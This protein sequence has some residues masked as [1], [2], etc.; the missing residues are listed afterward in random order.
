MSSSFKV[1]CNY[2][3]LD[4]CKELEPDNTAISLKSLGCHVF[5]RSVSELPGRHRG[6]KFG[7]KEYRDEYGMVL[8][9]RTRTTVIHSQPQSKIPLHR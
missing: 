7:Y 3:V 2:F 1:P 5:I 6:A 8:K 4:R 9:P